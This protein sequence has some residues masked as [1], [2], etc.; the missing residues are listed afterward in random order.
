MHSF[1]WLD[2]RVLADQTQAGSAGCARS[3]GS[4]GAATD[5][6]LFSC[7]CCGATLFFGNTRCLRCGT[8]VA[9]APDR[10]GFLACGEPGPASRPA[11]CANAAEG[12]CDWLAAEDD[13]FCQSCR[14]NRIIPNLALPGARERWGK[15]E[16]AKR[17]VFYALIRLGI[18]RPNRVD[19]PARGLAFDFLDEVP[20][21]T[22][23]TGHENGVITV[24]AKEAD[25]GVREALR[26]E[27]GE[28]YR[29]LVGHLRHETGHWIWDRLVSAAGRLDRFRALFGD[30]RVDYAASLARHYREGPP[31]GWQERTITPYATSHPW[32]DFAE[33]WAHYLHLLDTTETAA[34]FGLASRPAGRV[35]AD[36]GGFG[37]LP[38]PYE[39]VSLDEVLAG[40]GR[41]TAAGNALNA[42]MGLPDLYPFAFGTAVADKLCFMHEL[43]RSR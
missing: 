21:W 13:S 29:T 8:E 32:E 5:V 34:A 33:T 17:R 35:G 41:L 30:E 28:S 15:L 23:V 14:H 37:P 39:A 1:S 19:D 40:W 27:M 12:V 4:G 10:L 36:F 11:R 7:P 24:A 31:A 18:A 20:G 43:A 3:I 25:E 2:A 6:R 22:V 38:D 26:R 16:A 42:S 9:F